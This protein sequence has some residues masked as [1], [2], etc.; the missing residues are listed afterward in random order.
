MVPTKIYKTLQTNKM[1]M[2]I[3]LFCNLIICAVCS[4]EGKPEQTIPTQNSNIH[5][6]PIE[7]EIKNIPFSKMTIITF[8]DCE[9]LIYKEEHDANETM[10]FMA[11][12][13]NCNNPI[14]CYT[15]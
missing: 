14:H 10:G 1:K 9:Y 3:I 2:K 8:D 4:C 15:E 7:S 13:G 5:E 11:H 6:L 12:K